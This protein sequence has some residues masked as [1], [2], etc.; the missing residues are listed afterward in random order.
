[1]AQTGK[2]TLT[3]FGSRGLCEP[4]RV[5]LAEAKVEYDE[6]SLGAFNREKQGQGFV[7]LIA[8]GSL[9]FNL[10]PLWQEHDGFRLTQS[11][12]IVHHLARKYHL[13]GQNENESARTDELAEGLRDFAGALRSAAGNADK[14]AAKKQIVE[15]LSPKW[16]GFYEK[17][18]HAH[19]GG[20][21]FFVG[22]TLTY[23]DLT[24]WLTL[25][26]LVD[27]H[28]IHI[29]A[30]PTLK[31]FKERIEAKPT[32]AAYRTCPKRYPIQNIL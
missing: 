23:F 29:D 28:L 13:Y 30:F 6:I 3:Y 15:E 21:G 19:E 7:D 32:V 27:Q 4:I 18:L 8:S 9:P 5:L 17:I 24:L 20:K 11:H 16:F 12:A 14:E 22:H 10:V 2:P 25:E 26:S 31:G 1:M